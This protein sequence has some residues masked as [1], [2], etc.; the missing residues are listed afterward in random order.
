MSVPLM[1][2]SALLALISPIS[3]R[4]L[5]AVLPGE[6]A[7]SSVPG[8]LWETALQPMLPVV[9]SLASGHVLWMGLRPEL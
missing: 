5:G 1:Q 3:G 2:Q 8:M 4:D 6:P 7:F 9:S